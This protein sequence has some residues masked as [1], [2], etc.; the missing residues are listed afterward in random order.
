MASITTKELEAI[1]DQL[2]YELV[3]I[4]KFQT[5]AN[6]CQNAE[7]KNKCQQIAGIHQQHFDKLM[8][9]LN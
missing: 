5:Y 4:R 2:S 6:T 9:Y 1:E 8:S 7:I 3:L